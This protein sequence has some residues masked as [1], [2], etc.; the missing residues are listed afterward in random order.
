[1]TCSLPMQYVPIK[2]VLKIDQA[3]YHLKHAF[4]SILDFSF[5]THDKEIL[6][7]GIIGFFPRYRICAGSSSP[8]HRRDSNHH[9][10]FNFDH[11]GGLP[12][13][14]DF[15][16]R[17]DLGRHRDPSLVYSRRPVG[18][19]QQSSRTFDGTG[20]GLGSFKGEHVT[21]NNPNVCPKEEDWICPDPLNINGFRSLPRGWAKKVPIDFGAS[22]LPPPRHKGRGRGR[23]N[24]LNERKWYD[25]RPLSPYPPLPPSQQLLPRGRWQR[26][27]REKSKSPIR[28]APSPKEYRQEMYLE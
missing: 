26:D 6:T 12:R 4:P 20:Y 9:C 7:T 10:G 17:R 18:G 25:G 14:R 19:R 8:L 3:S 21:R 5:H 2:C 16:N 15:V 11:S 27:V 1:M 28:G 24:F 22:G 23:D 13:S